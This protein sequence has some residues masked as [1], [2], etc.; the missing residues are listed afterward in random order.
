ML[1]CDARYSCD[2]SLRAR[3][4]T[5]SQ[6]HAPPPVPSRPVPSRPVPSRPVPSR[7]VPSRPVPQECDSLLRLP[8][9]GS[10]VEVFVKEDGFEVASDDEATAPVVF[11]AIKTLLSRALGSLNRPGLTRT[12]STGGGGDGAAGTT[13]RE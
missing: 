12:V 13:P 11:D 10:S 5:S 3:P 7:P 9:C 2:H 4:Y 8:W 1:E 6:S